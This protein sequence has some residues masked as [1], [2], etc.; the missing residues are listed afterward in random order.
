[1]NNNLYDKLNAI[2]FRV[3]SSG[4]S[5]GSV[6]IE[7]TLYQASVNCI[8]DGRL[9]SLLC[10][11]V[12]V[13]GHNVI[14]EKLISLEKKKGESTWLWALATYAC[15][16]RFNRWKRLIKKPLTKIYLGDRDIE[17]S[18]IE[19]KGIEEVF[20]KTNFM[21][22]KGALRIREKDV[23]SESELAKFNV[24]YRNRFLYGANLRSDIITLIQLGFDKPYQISKF[25]N[26]NNESSQR[27]FKE[28]QKYYSFEQKETG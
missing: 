6:D 9:F 19:L 5:L 28:F 17:S 4:T 25:L 12:S 22:P 21:I 2:G 20:R 16:L 24:Q 15:S 3:I 1:M 18:L 14:I 27:V 10:S 13:H 26:C 7:E 23:M 8:N 11:W